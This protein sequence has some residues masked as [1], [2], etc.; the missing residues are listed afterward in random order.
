M[1]WTAT[2]TAAIDAR[3]TIAAADSPASG[4]GGNS[5]VFNEY[6]KN[7]VQYSGTTVPPIDNGV[8]LS[9]TLV[10]A[11][12]DWDLT[13]VP[14]LK[15]INVNVDLSTKK[16]VAFLFSNPSTTNNLTIA[17]HPTTNGY[18]LFGDAN[19]Q[20]TLLPGWY[21]LLGLEA[22]AANL[23]AVSATEKVIRIT[24]TIGQAIKLAA[25]FD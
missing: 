17:P 6:N 4:A 7:N 19:G 22:I 16:L 18:N 14:S 3:E 2:I 23:P 13:A 5:R 12:K 8:D 9:F 25:Y 10:A 1:S 24:G 11:D 20:I 15:D 21:G